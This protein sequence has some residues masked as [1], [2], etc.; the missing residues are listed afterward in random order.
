[1]CL[2][3]CNKKSLSFLGTT[4]AIKGL[5]I[6]GI[7]KVLPRDTHWPVKLG[8]ASLANGLFIV[9]GLLVRDGQEE[10]AIQSKTFLKLTFEDF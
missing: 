7:I 9:F 2:L 4:T 3:D 10:R 1:M 8:K 5:R 6:N